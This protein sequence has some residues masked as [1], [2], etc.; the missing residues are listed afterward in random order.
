MHENEMYWLA[1]LLE[2]EGCFTFK[3]PNK[4]VVA[5]QMTDEDVMER[6]HALM[7][8]PPPTHRKP[9]KEHHK[10]SWVT[11]VSGQQAVDLMLLVRP[12]MGTRRQEQI[13]YAVSSY[14]PHLLEESWQA[15]RRLT[16]EQV[17]EY[18]RRHL[19][20]ESGKKLAQ[21]AG[22]AHTGFYRM[23]KGETYKSVPFPG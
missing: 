21:E 9:Q 17:I 12:Y 4:P 22:L 8:S 2:G 16:E 14:N 7:G 5:L 6:A 3:R 1:G 13:D 19:T 23:L 18:R 11:Q 15:K 10:A 20:G